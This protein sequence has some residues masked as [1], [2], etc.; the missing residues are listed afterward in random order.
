MQPI[1]KAKL[2]AA[3]YLNQQY[4]SGGVGVTCVFL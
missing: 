2:N 4:S 3:L 1:E